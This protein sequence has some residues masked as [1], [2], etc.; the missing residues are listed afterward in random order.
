MDE[1]RNDPN[2]SYDEKILEMVKSEAY[3]RDLDYNSVDFS[4]KRNKR[5]KIRYNNK[6]IHFGSKDG[7]TFLDYILRG[8]YEKAVEKR[9]NW[10]KRHKEIKDE[11]GNA[12]YKKMNSPEY[13][14][15]HLLW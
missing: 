6:F 4:E 8:E 11:Y 1:L 14:S 13:Y 15:W 12:Y 7:S 2:L 10:R 5:F 3:A 9:K